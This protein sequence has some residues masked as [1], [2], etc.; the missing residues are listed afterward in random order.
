MIKAAL[1]DLDGT[2]ADTAADLGYAL[3]RLRLLHGLRELPFAQIRPVASHGTRG[4]LKLGFKVDP[5]DPLFPKLREMF[6][7]LYEENLC[8]ETKLFPGMPETLKQLETR[9]LAWGI[10]TNKPGRFTLPLMKQLGLELRAACI[11]SGDTCI[12]PKPHPAPLLAACEVMKIAPKYCVYVG[13]DLRD[14][15]AGQAANMRT[16]VA[17]YGYLGNGADP[18]SWGASGLIEHPKDLLTYL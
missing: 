17:G 18:S 7:N 16:I 11:I 8:R 9:K 4:L 3:N 13:D 1:F 12:H 14:I 2:L 10:V 6:L 5:K 15:Q